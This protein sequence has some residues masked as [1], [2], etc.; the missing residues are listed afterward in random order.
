M[1]ARVGT[2]GS[3]AV[4]LDLEDSVPLAEKAATRP[5]VRA[6]LP[7]VAGGPLRYVR[8]N[9]VETGLIFEDLDAVV[10]STSGR[11]AAAQS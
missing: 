9:A 1:V 3:D 11:S 10:L 5:A 4:I 6:V 8:V 7:S 2:F